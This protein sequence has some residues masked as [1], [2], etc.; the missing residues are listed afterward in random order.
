MSV[1]CI[2]APEPPFA[3][4][5]FEKKAGVE[6]RVSNSLSVVFRGRPPVV[7]VAEFG[8][9]TFAGVW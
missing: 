5:V 2:I 7:H 1:V 4:T 6:G 8:G 3:S 9:H